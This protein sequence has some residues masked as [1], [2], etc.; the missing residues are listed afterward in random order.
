M[1]ILS[2][3]HTLTPHQ[4]N[5]E[6][7]TDPAFQKMLEAQVR[8]L[9]KILREELLQLSQPELLRR[10][11]TQGISTELLDAAKTE[12][13]PTA[14]IAQLVMADALPETFEVRAKVCGASEEHGAHTSNEPFL[15]GKDA[16]KSLEIAVPEA[17]AKHIDSATHQEIRHIWA[18]VLDAARKSTREQHAARTA[19]NERRAKL[20][21]FAA[22]TQEEAAAAQ[23]VA[24]P[25]GDQPDEPLAHWVQERGSLRSLHGDIDA[26]VASLAATVTSLQAKFAQAGVEQERIRRTFAETK[27]QQESMMVS[28]HIGATMLFSILNALDINAPLSILHVHFV[29]MYPLLAHRR[30][31]A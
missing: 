8:T 26:S 10:A 30:D 17:H 1:E 11:K 25:T 23:M 27:D 5:D 24:S 12:A 3:M 31:A 19:A 15:A 21:A 28:S 20:E 16:S 6:Q 22:A 7:S 14:S 18:R 29:L 2:E 13:D 4:D 9:Q